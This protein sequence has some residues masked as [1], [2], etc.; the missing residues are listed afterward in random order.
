MFTF[1][2]KEQFAP[3]RPAPLQIYIRADSEGGWWCVWQTDLC[4]KLSC[5]SQSIL[6]PLVG[7]LIV[8]FGGFLWHQSKVNLLTA[9]RTARF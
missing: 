3:S 7:S 5:V 1:V 8:E 2:L 6:K 4:L 9:A